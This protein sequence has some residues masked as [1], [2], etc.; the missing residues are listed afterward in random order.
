MDE[1]LERA[2][3]AA[4]EEVILSGKEDREHDAMVICILLPFLFGG[5]TYA[6]FADI[7]QR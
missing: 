3:P 6:A 1:T 7:Q 5:I 4:T 2:A